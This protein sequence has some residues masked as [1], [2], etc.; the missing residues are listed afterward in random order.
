[1][2]DGASGIRGLGDQGIRDWG[3]E[4]S[5]D[6]GIG[7]SGDLGI[8]GFVFGVF[9]NQ[10]M[11]IMGELAGG[12][13]A[14]V[15][16]A[17]S[18]RWHAACDTS[19]VACDMGPMTHTKNLVLLLVLLSTHFKRFSVFHIQDFLEQGHSL[20]KLD[21]SNDDS[22]CRTAPASPDLSINTD[23]WYFLQ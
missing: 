9:A 10:L 11:C 5:G 23:S 2:D 17:I 4:G 18:D 6:Q 22:L 21:N 19:H 14:A 15:A 7:R 3:I 16:V 12:G 8:R 13:S 20:S 1:M